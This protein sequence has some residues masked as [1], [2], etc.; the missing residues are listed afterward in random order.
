MTT[1]SPK[2]QAA[3]FPKVF[4]KCQTNICVQLN[5]QKWFL[6][7]WI[8]EVLAT[9]EFCIVLTQQRRQLAHPSSG[10]IG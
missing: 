2:Y 3:L 5:L 7:V 1:G 6:K 8:C 10:C 4:A 9:G